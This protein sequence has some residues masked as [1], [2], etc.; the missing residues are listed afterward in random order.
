MEPG[1]GRD[2]RAAVLLNSIVLLTGPPLAGCLL[3]LDIELREKGPGNLG[4]V[5]GLVHCQAK[6]GQDAVHHVGE[7]PTAGLYYGADIGPS[8]E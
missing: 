1:V 5:G 7:T 6:N 2:S 3:D 8:S 4:F